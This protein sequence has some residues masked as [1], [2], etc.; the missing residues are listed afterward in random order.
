MHKARGCCET[1][2]RKEESWQRSARVESRNTVASQTRGILKTLDRVSG[3]VAPRR[4]F[5][6]AVP[7]RRSTPKADTCSKKNTEEWDELCET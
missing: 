6:L 1:G 4:T 5:E 3:R 2:S 7:D